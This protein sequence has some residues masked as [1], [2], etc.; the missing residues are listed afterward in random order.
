MFPRFDSQ[1]ALRDW[2]PSP[3]KPAKAANSEG[4][5]PSPVSDLAGL[6]ALAGGHAQSC[7]SESPADPGEYEERAAI[8]ERDGGYP[9]EWAEGLARLSTMPRPESY[10][11]PAWEALVNDAAVFLDR[12]GA[13]AMRLG[14]SVLDCFGVDPDRPERGYAAA[15]LVALLRG[16]WT[17]ARLHADRADL[18]SKATGAKQAFYRAALANGARPAWELARPKT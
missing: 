11:A 1:A 13:E 6:A 3:A 2:P 5:E 8:I 17:V 15:G 9:R 14:W 10:T 16:E 18:V 12:H 7:I 4:T